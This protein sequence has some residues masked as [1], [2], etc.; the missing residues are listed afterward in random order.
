[1]KTEKNI[2]LLTVSLLFCFFLIIADA[3]AA[4]G[5]IFKASE[6][7]SDAASSDDVWKWESYT[8]MGN[9]YTELD[10]YNKSRGRFGV[11]PENPVNEN[12]PTGGGWC[13]GSAWNT[14]AVGRYWMIPLI[15]TTGTDESIRSKYGV[16]KSFTAPKSGNVTLSCE[17][18]KIYGG[19]KSKDKDN[20]T[21]FIRITKNGEQ[22]WPS[23]G[24][25]YQ[26]PCSTVPVQTV[27]F[28]PITL[29]V[30]E[31]DVI[32]FEAY[33]GDGSKGYGKYVYW[34]PVVSYNYVPESI[35]PENLENIGEN[36]VFTV[37]F[38]DMISDM[39]KDNIEILSEDNE[40][41]VS[42]F[43]MNEDGKSISFSF[44]GLMGYTSYTVNI[45]GI[46]PMGEDTEHSCSFS[47]T[48]GDIF[49][50]PVYEASDAWSESS[51][52]DPVWRWLYRNTLSGDR[53]VEYTLTA[54]NNTNNYVAP[55]KGSDGTYDYSHVG[56]KSERTFVFCD[57]QS[58]AYMRNSVGRYWARLSVG[59]STEPLQNPNNAIVKSFTAPES[60]TVKISAKDMEGQSKIYNRDISEN[61]RLGAVVKVIRKAPEG[62]EDKVLW[63]H[64]FNYINAVIPSDGVAEC[65]LE[66]FE[67]EVS[68]GEQLWFV[69]S[70]E[71][72]GSAYSKQVF[73][74]PVVSYMNI[75]P[76]VE[77]TIPE[78]NSAD[79]DTN[80]V[81]K[82][83]FD[84]EIETPDFYDI[85]IDNGAEVKT[86]EVNDKTLLLVFSGLKSYTK[87]T[88]RLQNIRIPGVPNENTRVYEYSFTTG[89]AV[90]FGEISISDGALKAGENII[91]VGINN[92]DVSPYG[93][94]LLAAVCRGDENNYEIERILYVRRE[95]IGEND[96][97]SLK[98]QLD[99][100][101]GYM[102][103]ALLAESIPSARALLPVKIFK[104]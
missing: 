65:T 62:G 1:M 38:P 59:T 63:S 93:A 86:V 82:I 88:V 49:R 24:G 67:A 32:R 34:A 51:N 53:F 2:M 91:S 35:Y 52:N 75:I 26:I 69:I 58:N 21:A 92:T 64:S 56:E 20:T 6:S 5:E 13:S 87:Y 74:N 40:A 9:T 70:G 41:A 97:L 101:E 48:T 89:S 73:F 23:G 17:N 60:G 42:S 4:S 3:G 16:C 72:G 12:A 33:N 77:S 99:S 8:D 27:S 84:H 14:A 98:V 47:F 76:N 39:T 30:N 78:N 90:S 81:H 25:E 19:A 61:N 10:V 50:Y 29:D 100:S 11:D 94:T 68:K 18:G 45:T 22:I 104:P 7:W 80:F 15:K 96:S 54:Q 71:L 43:S 55:V 102:I 85:E 46:V 57:S 95:D 83:A 103:K 31:G 79:I 36:Q 44:S 28:S 66:P 37:T